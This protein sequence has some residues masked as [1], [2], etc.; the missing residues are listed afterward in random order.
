LFGL[1]RLGL[2]VARCIVC[3]LRPDEEVRAGRRPGMIKFGS[4]TEVSVPAELVQEAR[5]K[6]GD[7]VQGGSTIL[8]R[9]KNGGGGDS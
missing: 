5:V 3:W 2:P 7:T 4:R 8:L 1:H 9:L 6:V